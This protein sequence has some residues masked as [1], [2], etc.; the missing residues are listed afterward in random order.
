MVSKKAKKVLVVAQGLCGSGAEKFLKNLIEINHQ[1]NIKTAVCSPE[2]AT[3]LSTFFESY[4]VR[5]YQTYL[6]DDGMRL[7]YSILGRN[8][9]LP[10][11]NYLFV[12]YE[13]ISVLRA[14]ILSRPTL[15]L[16]SNT[17]PSSLLGL[18][19]YPV[20]VVLF[21]HTLVNNYLNYSKSHFLRVMASRL[22]RNKFATVSVY[23]NNM[24]EKYWGIPNS[25][26]RTIPNGVKTQN[27]NSL[28]IAKE[29]IILSVGDF[30]GY[31]NPEVW[32][33]VAK[34]F[35]LK[36]PQYR[37]LWVG[38]DYLNNQFQE[39]IKA[40]NL[41]EHI[42]IVGYSSNISAYYLKSKIY[43]H[44]SLSESQGI[45]ILE[46]MSFGLPCVASCVGGI[47]ESVIHKETGF[48]CEPQDI[49]SFVSYLEKLHLDGELYKKTSTNSYQRVADYFSPAK[50]EEKI[51]AM[52]QWAFEPNK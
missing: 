44:P 41:T 33:E 19:I 7:K 40:E 26:Q 21:A 28:S 9:R 23:S 29:N 34:K 27:E 13:A 36:Y 6:L 11:S 15:I 3:H 49:D 18:F 38:K 20:P 37:F 4:D 10:F 47:P 17:L 22:F 50:N 39:K 48:L 42:E 5:F 46:A 51:L 24:I 52:Y 1:N 30:V 2:D 14:Y 8:I 25:K 43:F 35:V 12:I 16:V 45:S 32:F 31:K